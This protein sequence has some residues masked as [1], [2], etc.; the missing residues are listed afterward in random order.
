MKCDLSRWFLIS[1]AV[2]TPWLA[3]GCEKPIPA[4]NE[5]YQNSTVDVASNSGLDTIPGVTSD[6]FDGVLRNP[7]KMA[8]PNNDSQWTSESRF[9]SVDHN[10][11]KIAD[12]MAGDARFDD[13]ANLLHDSV[14]SE[15]VVSTRSRDPA[16]GLTTVSEGRSLHTKGADAFLEFLESHPADRVD[17]KTVSFSP[18]EGGFESRSLVTKVIQTDKWRAQENSVWVA[19]WDEKNL[20]RNLRVTDFHES[21]L[22]TAAQAAFQDLAPYI[23]G[24]NGSYH[25]QLVYGTDHWRRRL[26]DVVGVDPLGMQGLALGDADGDGLEDLYVCQPGGLPNR[27]YLRQRDGTLLDRSAE[28]GLDWLDLTRS[29]LWADFDGDGDQDLMVAMDWHVVL[30]GQ[31]DGGFEPVEKFSMDAEPHSMAAADFDLDGDLDVY[32]CGRNPGGSDARQAILGMPTPY[33]DA[34]NGGPNVLLENSGGLRFEKTTA[35]RGLDMNNR[36][37]SYACVWEDYDLDGDPD[38]YVAN[39]FGRNN[40]YRNDVNTDGRFRDVAGATGVEDIGAGMGV[41]SGDF[42]RDGLPDFYVSNMFSAAGNR[43]TYQNEFAALH[44]RTVKAFQRHARGNTLFVNRG[45]GMGFEDAENALGGG[46]GRWAWGGQFSDFNND[47][48]PDLFVA[49]GFVSGDDTGDL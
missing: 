5:V 36:R 8:D 1:A 48:W 47:G 28:S 42:N 27:L 17:I 3:S 2:C 35:E 40:L 20:L 38:L 22:A 16:P 41:V 7:L 44:A 6:R 33:H 10:L 4:G 14:E 49:N 18:V 30:F 21:R 31:T 11:H 37:F 26:P 12:W 24:V 39:D 19:R 13:P 9:V 45:R 29:A 23:L 43:I 46:M 32:V 34:N 25:N 15:W